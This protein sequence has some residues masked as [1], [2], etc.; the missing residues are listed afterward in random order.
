MTSVGEDAREFDS[1]SA[2]SQARAAA[3]TIIREWVIVGIAAGAYSRRSDWTCWRKGGPTVVTEPIT[4]IVSDPAHDAKAWHH[5]IYT[6]PFLNHHIVS[7]RKNV[8]AIRFVR[9]SSSAWVTCFIVLGLVECCQLA[10][11]RGN[12]CGWIVYICVIGT[13]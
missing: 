4:W 3:P 9:P 11:R 6:Q 8:Y 5:Q 13:A 10:N 7:N 12:H 2:L 1:G